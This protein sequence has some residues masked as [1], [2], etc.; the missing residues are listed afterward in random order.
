MPFFLF[1]RFFVL[2]LH[3]ESKQNTLF[4]MKKIILMIV[5][6]AMTTGIQ[7][8]KVWEMEPLKLQVPEMKPELVQI[9]EDPIVFDFEEMAPEPK[10][11]FDFF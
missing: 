9:T 8:E 11:D 5:A 10:M 3:S 7:A 6:I 2:S 1:L 4:I